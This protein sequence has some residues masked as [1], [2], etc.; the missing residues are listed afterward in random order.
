MAIPEIGQVISTNALDD[1]I[2][3][4]DGCMVDVTG[5]SIPGLSGS[6][7]QGP[8]LGSVMTTMIR[9]VEKGLTTSFEP[10]VDLISIVKNAANPA[11]LISDVASFAN[12]LQQITQ[13]PE[14]FII[15]KLIDPI[16]Q[17]MSIPIPSPT[18]FITIITDF[19]S[20]QSL[21][22]ILAG[23][24]FSGSTIIEPQKFQDFAQKN[25]D[26]A[27]TILSN[28]GKI[29]SGMLKFLMIPIQAIISFFKAF[30]A[31]IVKALSDV[32]GFVAQWI[33]PI[34]GLMT[35]LG[36][37]LGTVV[38]QLSSSLFPS[39]LPNTQSTSGITSAIVGL[40]TGSANSIN[41]TPTS[42]DLAT[43]T[44]S[45]V[46]SDFNKSISDL[47]NFESQNSSNINSNLIGIYSE[48]I[49]VTSAVTL[50]TI[51]AQTQLSNAIS[52]F[53]NIDTSTLNSIELSF[54][55]YLKSTTDNSS[56]TINA[57]QNQ[58]NVAKSQLNSSASFCKYRRYGR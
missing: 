6:T 53:N 13:N 26:Q 11:A 7:I 36:T 38:G 41:I 16:T 49:S 18:T 34:K 22:K 35:M 45:A 20:G 58:L 30:I 42:L 52:D 57:V 25:E 46:T 54:M 2:T 44:L 32:V 5:S 37:I 24:T 39:S 28:I 33:N 47:N 29:I 12:D 19:I 23:I 27:N 48:I 55:N 40:F 9:T 21:D 4:F 15:N 31:L 1:M 14:Q 50:R 56:K 51:D 43:S 8:G 17:N 3:K 10:F